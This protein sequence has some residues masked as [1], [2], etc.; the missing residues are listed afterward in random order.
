M[1]QE[2]GRERAGCI[3]KG[4]LPFQIRFLSLPKKERREKKER[5]ETFPSRRHL[6]FCQWER[7]HKRESEEG[8]C[9]L[10]K[11]ERRR[12]EEDCGR[13][14]PPLS[15]SLPDIFRLIVLLPFLPLLL[16]CDRRGRRRPISAPPNRRPPK[17]RSSVAA[18]ERTEGAP[19]PYRESSERR[20]RETGF[21][22]NLDHFVNFSSAYVGNHCAPGIMIFFVTISSNPISPRARSQQRERVREGRHKLK[23]R[24]EGE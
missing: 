11:S 15:L 10:R 12:E 23:G 7:E 17:K 9:T 24:R 22:N 8:I 18:G 5:C 14:P 20:R 3:V 4:G 16:L 6:F 1:H 19:F 21:N 2:K 13:R